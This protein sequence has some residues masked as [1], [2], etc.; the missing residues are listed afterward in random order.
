LKIKKPWTEEL[1][2][3]RHPLTK[4]LQGKTLEFFC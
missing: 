1:K 4:E 3:K 2:V